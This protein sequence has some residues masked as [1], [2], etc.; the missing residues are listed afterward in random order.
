MLP[1]L[2]KFK[3]GIESDNS[4]AGIKSYSYGVVKEALKDKLMPCKLAFF[5]SIAEENEPF[6]TRFQSDAPMAP[7]LYTELNS[8]IVTLLSMIVKNEIMT[9]ETSVFK[10]DLKDSKN[11]ILAMEFPLS[12]SEVANID[13][14]LEDLCGSVVI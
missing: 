5:S 13:Q 3:T 6:L 10:I 14:Q 12:F 4:Y 11:L 7:F 8:I 9:K 2:S 1:N